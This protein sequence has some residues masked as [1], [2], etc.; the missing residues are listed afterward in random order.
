LQLAEIRQN[1][2]PDFQKQSD[3]YFPHPQRLKNNGDNQGHNRE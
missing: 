3:E 2:H 1:L